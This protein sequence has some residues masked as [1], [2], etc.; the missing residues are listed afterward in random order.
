MPAGLIPSVISIV[1]SGRHTELLRF[2]AEENK[3]GL[4]RFLFLVPVCSVYLEFVS[5]HGGKNRIVSRRNV[6]DYLP[7]SLRRRA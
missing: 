7:S 1:S 5:F 4:R 2:P 6:A 3:S